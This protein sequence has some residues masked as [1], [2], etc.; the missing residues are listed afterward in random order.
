MLFRSRTI[1]SRADLEA[2]PK[3]MDDF[4]KVIFNQ[5][6]PAASTNSALQ[7]LLGLLCVK[8]QPLGYRELAAM[9]QVSEDQ[10]SDCLEPI[11]DLLRFQLSP[12]SDGSTFNDDDWRISF[13]HVSLEQWLTAR[14]DGPFRRYRAGRFA[15]D[16]D[17]AKEQIHTWALAEVQ[18][19]RAHTWP[20]LVRHL[21]SHLKDDER[22][23][24]IGGQLLQFPWLQAR[25][26]LAGLTALLGDFNPTQYEP[27][28][29]PPE[30]IPLERAL[31][32][33]AH[34][35]SHEEGWNGQEQLASQLLARL[36][37]GA[38]PQGLELQARDWL[39]KAGGARPRAASLVGQIGRAHV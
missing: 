15:V 16:P 6:F 9:A 22:A 8:Q 28:T 39:H 12:D 4:Y 34:V 35:L 18:A 14:S 19:G 21:A 3:G 10:I 38:M 20:Y 7:P 1:Q 11:A 23:E 29:L 31:R 30:A 36:P 27:N 5:R 37:E 25:L 2:L 13:D 32:Q 17:T 26:K 24:V 33:A